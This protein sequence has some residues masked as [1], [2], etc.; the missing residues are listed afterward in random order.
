MQIPENA[1]LDYT[2]HG[3]E[4]RRG[5]ARSGNSCV[6]VD[7]PENAQLDYTGHSWECRRGYSRLGRGCQAVL[8]PENAELDYTGHNWQCITA[9]KRVE[10]GCVA[11]T[12]SELAQQ[13]QNREAAMKLMA[14]R[15]VGSAYESGVESAT[16]QVLI[17]EN[18]AIVEVSRG[19]LG[20]VRSRRQTIVFKDGTRWSVWIEGKGVYPCDILKEPARRNTVDTAIAYISKVSDSGE[21][22]ILGDGS[23]YEVSSTDRIYSTLWLAASKIV[24]LDDDRMLNV[25]D[26]DQLIEVRRI[27]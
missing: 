25:D 6:A 4:C 12:P 19:S 16:G 13:Q 10:A 3:W 24:L 20:S 18:G 14:S 1:Q 2:G 23:V 26:A 22:V 9:Y 21:I 15:Q 8:V 5:F 27:R 11:M 7:V 17:L